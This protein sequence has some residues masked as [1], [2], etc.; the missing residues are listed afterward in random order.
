MCDKNAKSECIV[1]KLSTLI[2]ECICER[3]T[4]FHE[5][6]LLDRGVINL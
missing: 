1:I 6:I 3:A 2:F 5:K 4:K